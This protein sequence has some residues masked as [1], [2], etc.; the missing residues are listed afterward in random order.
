MG[1]SFRGTNWSAVASS[2][3]GGWELC[4]SCF[5]FATFLGDGR[6]AVEDGLA[7]IKYI[8]RH[9]RTLSLTYIDVL[10]SL[11]GGRRFTALEFARRSGN[12]RAAKVLSELKHR[13]FVERVGRGTYRC[14]SP[15][16]RPDLRDAEWSRVRDVVLSGP[17]PKAWA[18]ETALELWTG[19]R[20]R[21]APSLYARVFHLAVP[22]RRRGDWVRYLS[23]HR[24]STSSKKRVGARVEL[25]TVEG[26]EPVSIGGEPVVGR[27][28][29][30]RLIREHPAL[31]GN[32][33]E[34]LIG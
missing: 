17:D 1:L 4:V 16:E 9:C 33:G 31:Y 13:G 28:E 32:A 26:L 11:F 3:R 14:L 12:P 25:T 24:V 22:R 34:L 23:D 29:V 8:F 6:V 20:Y 27:S 7:I 19:G 30:E 10:S 21:L 15:G 2:T 5:L 18:G